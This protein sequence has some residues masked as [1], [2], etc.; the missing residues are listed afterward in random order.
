[1]KVVLDANVFIAALITRGICSALLKRCVQKHQVFSSDVVLAD[2]SE[3][4]LGKFKYTDEEAEEA[5]DLLRSQIAL[6]DAPPLESPVCRDPDDDHILALAVAAQ[7]RCIVTGDK[8]LLVLERFRGIE[9]L[10]PSAFAAY[11]SRES[12]T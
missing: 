5:L 11:E 7:A 9:I 12:D 8:D 1:M 10:G 4:L 6:I 3:H 2:V